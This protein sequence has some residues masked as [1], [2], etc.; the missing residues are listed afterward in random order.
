MREDRGG[1]ERAPKSAVTR[2][3]FPDPG[4]APRRSDATQPRRQSAQRQPSERE[5]GREADEGR[6]GPFQGTGT[7]GEARDS[8]LEPSHEIVDAQPQAFQFVRQSIGDG[9]GAGFGLSFSGER[10]G[11]KIGHVE[12]I[13]HR[14][15]AE[16]Q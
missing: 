4:L 9:Q 1:H 8:G 15:H 10:P 11:P 12:Q 2:H 7:G 6:D 3:C 16:F 5:P 13:A 14:F